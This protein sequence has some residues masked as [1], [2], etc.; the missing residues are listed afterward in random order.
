MAILPDGCILLPTI[1][2]SICVIL[3]Y[4]I[5]NIPD[6]DDLAMGDKNLLN[7]LEHRTLNQRTYDMVRGFIESGYLLPGTQLDERTLANELA[8]SRT[9]LREAIARLVEEGLVERHPY[10]GNFVRTFSAKQI[11]DLYVVRKTLEGL[12]V[13][14]AVPRLTEDDLAKL[15]QILNATDEA[16][17]HNDIIGYSSADQE[18]HE[19]IAH[20]T[21]N[22]I[23]IASIERLK[24]Q[25]QI[26]RVSANHDPEVVKRTALERP[27]ILA[28]LAARDAEQAAQL[29]EEHI[30]GVRRAVVA[31]IEAA[32]ALKNE[33]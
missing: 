32:E 24:R 19:T 23:L 14:L 9:P 30:E 4:T 22:E 10:R 7:K 8:I 28:A 25:I 21:E 2:L 3:W 15:G 27:R 6:N 33:L 26:M 5:Y 1:N 20:I 29:M 12:A 18:F 17:E 13:R 31:Q 11:N 16:L